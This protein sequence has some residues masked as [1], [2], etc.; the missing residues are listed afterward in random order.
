MGFAG[1]E[2]EAVA[3]S[4]ARRGGPSSPGPVGFKEGGQVDD[5]R[6]YH[7]KGPEQQG[8]EELGHD[9]AL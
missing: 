4:R 8:G 1:A 5:Q 9:G 2:E 6:H 7:R 3:K